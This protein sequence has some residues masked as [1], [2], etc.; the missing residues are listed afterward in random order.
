MTDRG[1]TGLWSGDAVTG[2]THG[3]RAGGPLAAFTIYAILA[4]AWT[5][6]LASAPGRLALPNADVFGNTWALAWVVHQ[7]FRDP[8]HLFEANLYYPH[9]RGLAYTESLLP[10]AA[11][12]APVL[13]MGGGPLLAHNL[14]ALLTFPLCGLGAYLLARE[15]S[16][17]GWGAFLAGLGYAFCAYR[18]SHLVHV[19]SLSMQWFPFVFLYL[20]RG[21]REGRMRDLAALAGFWVLQALSSGYYALALA[22]GTGLVLLM[23]LRR[24]WE[25]R[26]LLRV[27]GALFAAAAL[28]AVALLPY[29]AVQREAGLS[30]SRQEA[31]HW[32][33]RWSS[34]L[35]PGEYAW[36]GHLRYL[37]ERFGHRPLYPGTVIVPLAVLALARGRRSS[38]VA[39]P[40][41]L[42]LAGLALSLG[43][44]FSLGSLR[45]PGPFEALRAIPP[46][47]L[48]RTP[49]RM[50]VLT[51]LGLSL[52]A[53]HGWA[54]IMKGRR[55]EGLLALLLAI[56]M[57][58]E[59]FPRGLSH[60]IRPVPEPPPSATWLRSA[61]RGPVLE[62]PWDHATLGNGALY[63]YWSTAHWQPMVN[64]WG[65]F[66][67]RGPFE[68]GVIGHRWPSEY[69][70]R[71]FRQA[72]LRYVV[73]HLDR[74]SPG[75]KRRVLEGAPPEGVRLVF[76]SGWDRV[77]EIAGGPGVSGDGQQSR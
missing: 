36:L 45:V 8:L 22:A 7:G 52:L 5:W 21:L 50:A 32:S 16:G 46:V 74:V 51:F 66:E 6:P 43:P 47:S 40:L 77:Y 58:L 48:L 38:N 56:F 67:P 53:A 75:Q 12:A 19:Q 29:R 31:V 73:V 55:R 24:A 64:G 15:L 27:L 11:Q 60:Q 37:H 59:T 63:L 54:G 65:A 33:A 18:F 17:S 42:T 57:A 71:I 69:T 61:P 25:R 34:F 49:D 4:L 39:M 35:D 28:T 3:L 44:E 23:E 14:V 70:A 20:R 26:T 41:A 68:L 10:Q 1:P 13:L 2:A 62:L 9:R 76:D 30:R 72:R